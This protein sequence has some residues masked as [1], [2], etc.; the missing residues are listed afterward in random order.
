MFYSSA[1][2]ESFA[3]RPYN[4]QISFAVPHA[5]K[6]ASSRKFA[7]LRTTRLRAVPQTTGKDTFALSLSRYLG[8]SSA[9]GRTIGHAVA[10]AVAQSLFSNES[11]HSLAHPYTKIANPSP[12]GQAAVR[13]PIVLLNAFHRSVTKA[14]TRSISGTFAR[15]INLPS[16]QPAARQRQNH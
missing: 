11:L 1:V 10:H 9:V 12:A 7:S 5:C 16:A 14:T 3:G 4:S 15:A 2:F 6:R 8:N 13:L